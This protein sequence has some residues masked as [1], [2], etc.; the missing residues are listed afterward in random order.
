[1]IKEAQSIIKK[2]VGKSLQCGKKIMFREI[3]N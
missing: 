1:M 3:K 2:A